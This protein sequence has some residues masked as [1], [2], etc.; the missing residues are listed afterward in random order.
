MQRNENMIAALRREREVYVSRG[1]DE[2]VA[3]VDEQLRHYGYDTQ[4]DPDTGP[5]GRTSQAGQQTAGGSG[6]KGEAA[7]TRAKKTT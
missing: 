3:Q 5:Q 7:A 6:G 1:E 2:R 4:A